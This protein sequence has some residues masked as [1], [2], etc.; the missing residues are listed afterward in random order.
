MK[1]LGKFSL[2]DSNLLQLLCVHLNWEGRSREQGSAGFFSRYF[3][4]FLFGRSGTKD[5]PE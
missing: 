5:S 2:V 4:A 3:G 1:G